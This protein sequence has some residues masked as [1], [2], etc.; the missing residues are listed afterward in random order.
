M[1]VWLYE[2]MLLWLG[3]ADSL[4][5]DLF[6][7][8]SGI[9]CR[10]G[11]EEMVLK[12][13][14]LLLTIAPV[15]RSMSFPS[16]PPVAIHLRCPEGAMHPPRKLCPW[17]AMDG[18]RTMLPVFSYKNAINRRKMNEREIGIVRMKLLKLHIEVLLPS[19][20]KSTKR[21]IIIKTKHCIRIYTQIQNE[22]KLFQFI[23]LLNYN[24]ILSIK[25]INQ[26]DSRSWTS[27]AD[28]RSVQP[29]QSSIKNWQPQNWIIGTKR[30]TESNRC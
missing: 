7:I 2:M 24:H 14:L 4:A 25:M 6:R 18:S 16:G 1:V 15:A 12:M 30:F 28:C 21:Q 27:F 22:V 3:W 5:K 9:D 17:E 13:I 20:Q 26:T 19:T 23:F 8:K 10:I 29:E 11:G